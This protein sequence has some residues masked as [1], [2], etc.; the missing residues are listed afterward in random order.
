MKTYVSKLSE[1]KRKHE[2]VVLNNKKGESVIGKVRE[3]KKK[4]LVK[5]WSV[6]AYPLV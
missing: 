2:W 5:S 1:D 6:N 3:K 4:L